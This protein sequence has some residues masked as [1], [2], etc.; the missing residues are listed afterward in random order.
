MKAFFVSQRDQWE[1]ELAAG[2]KGSPNRMSF[3]Q[4]MRF[5]L[6]EMAGKVKCVQGG[7]AGGAHSAPGASSNLRGKSRCPRMVRRITTSPPANS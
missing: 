7:K 2:M 4:W 6:S 3:F 1:V 5:A